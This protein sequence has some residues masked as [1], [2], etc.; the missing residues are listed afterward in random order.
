M[1]VI[2]LDAQPRDLGKSASRA[3]RRNK[4]V[5]CVLYGPHAEPV[6]FRLS[7]LDMRPLIFTSTAHLVDLNLDGE[8]YSCI[9]KDV[10][11][12][13]VTDVPVHADFYALTAGEAITVT[14]PVVLTG[15]APGVEAGGILNQTLNEIELS[16]LPKHIPG[17][18]EVDISALGLGDSLHVSDLS[19]ENVEILTDEAR[20]V[21][22]INAPRKEEE[23]EAD[24]MLAEADSADDA[25]GEEPADDAENEA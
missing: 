13:P 10:T 16:C 12:H 21:V 4:E 24:E 6:H 3:I 7:V 9:L 17:S 5:P 23:P 8:T 25:A 22:T 15:S 14:V 20:T 11:Y 18:I 19:V 1:D 2:T